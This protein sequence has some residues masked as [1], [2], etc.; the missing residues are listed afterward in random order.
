MFVN[1]TRYRGGGPNEPWFDPIGHLAPISRR[2]FPALAEEV[3]PLLET[4]K[5][6]VTVLYLVKVECFVG[7]VWNGPGRPQEDRRALARGFIAK[8]PCGICRRPAI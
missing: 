5:R 3:G 1:T 8:A 6:F 2:T 4:H 7:E